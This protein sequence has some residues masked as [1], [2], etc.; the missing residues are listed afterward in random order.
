MS[1][2]DDT[3]TPDGEATPSQAIIEAI[4]RAEGV[5]VTAIEP[6]EYDPLYA[7][8][9]PEALDELFR[10]PPGPPE[11]ARVYLEY[12]GYEIVVHGDGRVELTEGSS[13]GSVNRP[14]E[15]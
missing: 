6:P 10:T 12:E 3:S 9:N 13:D 14:I 8:V 11:T 1:S 15:E 4:A 5:D 2:P 7:V